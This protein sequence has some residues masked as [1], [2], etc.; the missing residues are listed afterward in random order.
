[1]RS[2]RSHIDF[3]FVEVIGSVI[4]MLVSYTYVCKFFIK[5][6]ANERF[7]LKSQVSLVIVK[8]IV[9]DS[10]TSLELNSCVLQTLPPSC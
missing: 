9:N 2:S 6:A 8:N 7:S 5:K 4:Y 10:R 3:L 1:M